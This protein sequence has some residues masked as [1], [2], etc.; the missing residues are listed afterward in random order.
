ML[1]PGR[2]ARG[3]R[4]AD[5]G[6]HGR[7]RGPSE[8][9]HGSDRERLLPDGKRRPLGLPGRRRGT[10]TRDLAR[11]VL[12]RC[13]GRLQRGLRLLHRGDR[14][15]HRGGA[16]RL[17]VRL[18]RAPAGRLPTH[19]GRGRG[20]VVAQG[21]GSR[22]ATPGGPA[23][24]ARRSPRSPRPTCLLERR[25]G[26][27]HLGGRPPADRGR[28]GVRGPRGARWQGLPLGRRARA[29]RRAPDERLAGRLPDQ[30]HRGRRLLRNLPRSTPSRP[31]ATGSTT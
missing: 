7:R 18:R 5:R 28:V 6:D 27:L 12:D 3:A 4:P 29:R 14:L 23:V 11:F 24:V 20:P 9:R 26:V 13:R 21:G 22:L 8:R 2:A 16:I 19:P 25:P 31:T 30:Q 17:V 10:G 1:C 15:R